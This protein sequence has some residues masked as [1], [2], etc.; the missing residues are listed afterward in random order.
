[1]PPQ[2][3]EFDILATPVPQTGRLAVVIPCYNHAHYISRAIQSVLDQTRPVD[4]LIVIDDG[5]HDNSVEVVRA[6]GE[7]KVELYVQEN[8]N[9]FNTINRGVA[10]AATDCDFI[11][12]LNSDDHYTPDRF[13]KLLPLLESDPTAMVVCSGLNIIDEND[14]PLAADH[15]RTRW[16]EAIWSMEARDDL[17]MVEWIGLGNFP[18][19]TS[20]ILARADYLAANPMRPYHYNHD[21]YF[22][23]GAAVRGGLRILSESLV[24]YRVHT[25]NTMNTQPAKLMKE[26]L[27]QQVD[28]LREFEPE[29]R[30]DPEKRR[31]YKLYIQAA[32]ENI[33]AFDT[34]LFLQVLARSLAEGDAAAIDD[35]IR[36]MDTRDWPELERFPNRHH[37]NT[38]PGGG[39]LGMASTMPEKLDALRE[40]RD[41]AREE[42]AS[43]KELARLLARISADKKFAFGTAL[44]L[45]PKLDRLKGS[46]DRERLH[47][48]HAL[49]ANSFWLPRLG[50]P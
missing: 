45:A 46:N 26:L 32:F 42:A 4:R 29:M 5:S 23:T 20:N 18:A 21:Y 1:M 38:W 8:Q 49:L 9:A 30:L 22:L 48:L 36:S 37:V 40:Q 41:A 6:L 15:P 19:T 25:G 13:E 2:Q 10:M 14:Q 28:F 47:E 44:G 27:R 33:S 31:R 50:R 39:P 12:I 34:G 11:A 7:A 43:R 17:E 16:F 3:L 24:N 35:F